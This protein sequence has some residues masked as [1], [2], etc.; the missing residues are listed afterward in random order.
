MKKVIQIIEWIL[1]ILLLVLLAFL[2]KCFSVSVRSEVLV[3]WFFVVA[4]GWSFLHGIEVEVPIPFWVIIS[5]DVVRVLG[6]SLLGWGLFSVVLNFNISAS[7]SLGNLVLLGVSNVSWLVNVL[8]V[9]SIVPGEWSVSLHEVSRSSWSW[10]V[11]FL[12]L[13]IVPWEG[14]VSLDIPWER[15]VS[16]NEISWSSWSWSVV[17]FGLDLVE[18]EGSVSFNVPRERSVS[19]YI[20]REW[21]ISVDLVDLVARV[22]STSLDLISWSSW[23]GS[24]VLLGLNLVEWERSVSLNVP[25]EGSVSLDEI[26]W[27]SGSGSVL[28]FLDLIPGEG[29]VS[30]DLLNLIPWPWSSSLGLNIVPWEGSISLNVP[31]EWSISLDIPW[32]GSVPL[33]IPWEGSISLNKSSILIFMGARVWPWVWVWVWSVWVMWVASMRVASVWVASV[34]S[35]TVVRWVGSSASSVDLLLLSG[36]E[37]LHWGNIVGMSGGDIWVG[38]LGSGLRSHIA[39]LGGLWGHSAVYWGVII[40][41]NLD[42]WSEVSAVRSRS[43][44]LNSVG[45]LSGCTSGKFSLSWG[46][47]LSLEEVSLVLLGDDGAEEQSSGKGNV[48]LHYS[49]FWGFQ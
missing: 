46:L 29:S 42:N 45:S 8:E 40:V 48:S 2:P 6:I 36:S 33:D 31:R 11:V 21:S 16:L 28:D 24:V 14:S 32:E 41:S 10:S 44:S 3:G 30:V 20:P 7:W 18:R 43:S 35:V 9:G 25:R 5:E 12:C 22:R 27:S 1:I 49:F 26:S 39:W 13:D 37:V 19:L 47:E 38:V 15:S 17:L 34:G 4:I 23:S